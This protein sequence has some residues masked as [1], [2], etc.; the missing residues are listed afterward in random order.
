MDRDW[1]LLI[2]TLIKV[3]PERMEQSE[4]SKQVR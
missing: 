2:S 1:D 3:F 4:C